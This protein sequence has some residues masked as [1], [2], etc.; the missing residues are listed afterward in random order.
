MGADPI[1][2]S[3]VRVVDL[4]GNRGARGLASNGVQG[5]SLVDQ[6]RRM[7]AGVE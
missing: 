5:G 2:E 7:T 3:R 4:G 1:K 6:V